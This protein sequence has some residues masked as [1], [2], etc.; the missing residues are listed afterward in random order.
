[1]STKVDVSGSK[2]GLHTSTFVNPS[3]SYIM[4][5]GSIPLVFQPLLP[6]HFFGDM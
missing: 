1:M 3:F 2:L 5:E 6:G 4:T